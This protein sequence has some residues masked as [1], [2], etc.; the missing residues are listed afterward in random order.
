MSVRLLYLTL[1]R[2]FGWLV[3]LGRSQASKDVEIMVLRHEVAVLKRQVVRP[4]PDWADRALLAALARV[5]PSV[6]RAHRLVT[7]GTLLAGHRRLIKR[8]WT[9]THRTGRPGT[10]NEVRDLVLRLARENPRWGYRRVHG[11]LVRLGLQVS[12]ATVRRILRSRRQPPAPRS[13]DTSWRTFLRQQAKGLLACDFFHVDTVF[14]KRLYVLFVMEVETRRV[15]IPGVTAHPAGT[16]T[17]QQARNLFMDLG[18][19]ARSFRFLIRD[20]DAKFTAAFDEIFT[21]QGVTV[22]KTPPRTPRA[23]CYAER[24]IRTVRAECTDRMLIYDERHLRSVLNEYIEHYNAHRPH[25]SRWQRPPD[26]DEDV[27]VP[28]EG[29]IQRRRV[30]SGAIN[31]YHRAA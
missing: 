30:L 5:L 13:V 20:R 8:S 21:S 28:L 7:P 29:R 16:W 2:V 27:V 22:M 18:R 4:R 31:E 15:H 3:L 19:Q 24:W 10:S 6:L 23:N 14:L 1:I 11:E 9:Y 17:A 12:A 26:Q 25:Q